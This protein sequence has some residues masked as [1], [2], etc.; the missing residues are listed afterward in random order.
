MITRNIKVLI[1]GLTIAGPEGLTVQYERIECGTDA[2][3]R[4]YDHDFQHTFTA[5]LA[6]ALQQKRL[7]LPFAKEIGPEKIL[8][9]AQLQFL[10]EIAKP[11]FRALLTQTTPGTVK[12]KE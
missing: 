10:I 3:V 6:Y 1:S 5:P 4:L 8:S 2:T 9:E 11:I 7:Y 12:V